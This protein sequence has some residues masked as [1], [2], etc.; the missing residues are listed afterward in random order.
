MPCCNYISPLSLLFVLTGTMKFMNLLLST[1]LRAL[2]SE[3]AFLKKMIIYK[4]SMTP[5]SMHTHH[6][7]SLLRSRRWTSGCWNKKNN[8]AICQQ[9]QIQFFT[10]FFCD[11]INKESVASICSTSLFRSMTMVCSWDI[12]M[13]QVTFP[14]A[15]SGLASFSF[16][17]SHRFQWYKFSFYLAIVHDYMF[18]FI[19]VNQVQSLF[20]WFHIQ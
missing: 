7:Y 2:E 18:F 3:N 17:Y 15:C 1:K 6:F 5:K 14:V 4:L 13:I 11:G 10:L 19:C 16:P 9:I 12:R 20:Y 8:I